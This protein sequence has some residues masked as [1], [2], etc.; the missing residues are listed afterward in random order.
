[1]G[2]YREVKRV[3]GVARA[4]VRRSG[5]R[6]RPVPHRELDP[7]SGGQLGPF[8]GPLEAWRYCRRCGYAVIVPA[9]RRGRCSR[10]GARGQ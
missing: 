10:C 8:P 5:L 9:L 6:R 2:G 4:P 1:M 7:S 3:D